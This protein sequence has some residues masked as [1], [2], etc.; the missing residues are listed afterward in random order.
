MSG[1][2]LLAAIGDIH[3]CVKTLQALMEQLPEDRTFVFLGDYI[4]RGP[5]SKGVVQFLIDFSRTHHCVFLRGN[6]EQMMLEANRGGSEFR[7]WMANGGRSTLK[8]YGQAQMNFELP[9][10]HFHFFRNTQLFYETPEYVFVHGGLQPDRSIHEQLH[11]NDEDALF[12]VLWER[13][14][15]NANTSNWEKTVVYGHSPMHDVR[16]E[17]RQIG[18]DTG[19][20]YNRLPGL[21]LL[22]AILLPEMQIF[23]Q[24]CIDNP[25]PY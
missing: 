15:L 8:S 11:E 6:H 24:E 20:V 9:G 5:D 12:D 2:P 25:Q 22:T 18:I 7:I 21:G 17:P 4:D 1:A 23:Q 3:G 10:A 19:C 13:A 16:I 14:H